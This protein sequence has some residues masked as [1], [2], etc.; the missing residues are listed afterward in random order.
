MRPFA[1]KRRVQIEQGLCNSGA[2]ATSSDH[3]G[4][5]GIGSQ[6]PGYCL[7]GSSGTASRQPRHRIPKAILARHRWLIVHD[8]RYRGR[9]PNQPRVVVSDGT[10]LVSTAQA[11][12]REDRPFR[13]PCYGAEWR[14]AGRTA[15][16]ALC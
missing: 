7:C 11:S 6:E 16:D 15:A 4:V 9:R 12:Q 8:I 10:K 14:A 13:I 5:L 3:T 1:G 2:R